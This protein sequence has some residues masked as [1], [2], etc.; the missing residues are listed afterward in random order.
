MGAEHALILAPPGATSPSPDQWP[1]QTPPVAS[2]R[3][4][5]V[6]GFNPLKLCCKLSSNFHGGGSPDSGLGPG[7]AGQVAAIFAMAYLR[8]SALASFASGPKFT[9]SR[10]INIS[11][12]A[13]SS[14]S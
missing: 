13:N 10:L 4:T 7:S 9:N 12:A 6:L 1:L 5:S 3:C 14:V 8:S 2:E 11:L